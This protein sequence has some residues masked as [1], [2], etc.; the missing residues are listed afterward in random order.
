[1]LPDDRAARE[2]FG[3]GGADEI[4]AEHVAHVGHGREREGQAGK[5]DV[6][7]TAPG[8]DGPF[9][10]GSE[11]E[12]NGGGDEAGETDAD[13]GDGEARPVGD[14]ATLDGGKRADSDADEDGDH[15][16]E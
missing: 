6:V 7:D 11:H 10:F 14:A 9:Q 15:E 4:V 8:A 13:E 2:S 3:A 16:G 1:M 5:D 12:E